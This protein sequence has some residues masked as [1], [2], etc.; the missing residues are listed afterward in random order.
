MYTIKNH[1]EELIEELF[2]LFDAKG[3]KVHVE[4]VFPSGEAIDVTYHS[5]SVST[6]ER[7]VDESRL[8]WPDRLES[9]SE[10]SSDALSKKYSMRIF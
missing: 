6:S 8:I 7:V 10:Q 2:E 1:A 3:V 5:E 9:L 4:A